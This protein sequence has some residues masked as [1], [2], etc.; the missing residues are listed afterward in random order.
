MRVPDFSSVRLLVAG[1]VMLDQYWTGSTQRISPEAPVP[2][3]N[4]RAADH[5]AGGAANV[6][7]GLA[8]LGARV[9]LVGPVGEDDA[10]T[11]LAGLLERGGVSCAFRREARLRT[12]TKLRVLSHHQQMIRLDFEDPPGEAAALAPQHLAPWLADVDA[13]VLSDYGKGALAQVTTLIQAARAA[14]RAVLV[15]PK[16]ADLSVYRGASIVTPNR[17]E[18]ERAVGR[19]ATEEELVAKG[20]ELVERLSWEALLITRSEE[21]MTLLERRREPLHIPAQAH[22][23]YDVTGAGDT[24]IAVLAAARATGASWQAAARLANVAA[25]IAVGKLGTAT[26]SRSELVQAA[27]APGLRDAHG[28]VDEATLLARVREA[29]ARGERIVMT[30]GCFDI[31]HAGHVR[32][33][34]EARALGDRLVVAVNDD[35]SV[36]RLKGPTRPI[37]PLED[38]MAVLAAL[39]AVD[40][41]V[42]FSEDTPARLIDAVQPDVLVKGGD[43]RIDQIAGHEGVLARGGEVKVLRF[44][45]GRSTS[46]IV[47][48]IRSTSS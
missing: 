37:V 1:D 23:V 7:L 21:G 34:A 20:M 46:S 27:E 12:I 32:Y 9:T 47:D 16:Q 33:L 8:A 19:C 45:D 17:A 28:V 36:A 13:V 14:G 22:E 5:R 3:V 15:D 2:V 6:A 39:A 24:V 41:V 25:G 10:A 18:F 38:R 48:R 43:Y 29:R 26:V 11:T 4:V 42:P 44:V 40:W 31:L 35:A 30:N